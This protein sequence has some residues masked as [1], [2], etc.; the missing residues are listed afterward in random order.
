MV[1]YKWWLLFKLIMASH[2]WPVTLQKNA[3]ILSEKEIQFANL[4]LGLEQEHLFADWDDVDVNDDLK[5]RFFLQVER[6]H[7]TYPVEGGLGAYISRAQI[8]L[9]KSRNGENP[10]NGWHPEIP[11]GSKI[12][13]LS[14]LSSLFESIGLQEVG[15]CGFVLVAG[16]LGER[17]GYV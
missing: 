9:E 11:A 10:F 17:L 14:E 8:L 13:P 7:E 16:G 5:H 12:E 4:L 2:N 15:L 3:A 1:L 6:L